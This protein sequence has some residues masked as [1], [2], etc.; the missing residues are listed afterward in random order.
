MKYLKNLFLSAFLMATLCSCSD[1]MVFHMEMLQPGYVVVPSSKR[2]IVI[3]DNSGIQPREVGHEYTRNFKTYKDT[4]FDTEPLS[5]YLMQSL[6][7]YLLKEGFYQ[8]VKLMSRQDL[9]VSKSDEDDYLLSGRIAGSNICAIS[10]DP[11]V[12]L[13]FS[14]DRLLTRTVTNTR[15]DGVIYDVTRDVWVNS[16]W[17]IYDLESDTLICQFQYNDSL[18]WRKE[19]SSPIKAEYQ[20]PKMEDVLPEIGDVVAEHLSKHLG[21][22]W[23]KTFREFFCTGNVRMKMAADL[24]RKDSLDA[25]SL[26]WK[27]SYDKGHFRTKYRAAM[28][29]V[30]YSEA[31]GD[32]KAALEWAKRAET[33]MQSC[34]TGAA[35]YDEELLT[36]WKEVLEVRLKEYDK[37][38]I[39]FEGDL[40]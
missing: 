15:Y 31:K 32:P 34:P 2:N 26:L 37:L 20:L 30:M 38:K 3:A 36:R 28:N 12:Q 10:R 33:A 22:Y 19:S 25:A 16:V 18:F 8:Q 17:R 9:L 13:L 7:N 35:F 40:N 24:V 39:Y 4:A 5:G 1:R 23:E 29:M 21:P 14:L 6:S 11:G 27:N